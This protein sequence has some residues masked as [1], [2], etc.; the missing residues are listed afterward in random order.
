MRLWSTYILCMGTC[1]APRA[2]SEKP[3]FLSILQSSTLGHL[4]EASILLTLCYGVMPGLA[5][6]PNQ[7][8]SFSFCLT[9][10]PPR[11]MLFSS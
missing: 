11:L 9:P 3:R 8:L 6:K 10:S 4:A 2:S 5:G 1:T 7:P